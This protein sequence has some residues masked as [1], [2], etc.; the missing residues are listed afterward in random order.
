MTFLRFSR[1]TLL[2]LAVA[3]V[4][5]AAAVAAVLLSRSPP[6]SAGSG[7]IAFTNFRTGNG[8]IY[9][10]HHDGTGERRLTD[11]RAPDMFP[12]W[13]PD[14]KRI[15]FTRIQGGMSCSTDAQ[16]M[17]AVIQM[18]RIP[19]VDL[20]LGCMPKRLSALE[21]YVMNADGSGQHKLATGLGAVWSPEGRRIAYLRLLP[22]GNSDIYVV[23]LDGRSQRVTQTPATEDLPSWSPDGRRLAFDSERFSTYHGIDHRLYLVNDD[24]SG[25]RAL[26]YD[27]PGSTE[28]AWSPDGTKIA[29]SDSDGTISTLRPDR[30]R[31][32]EVPQ[33][34]REK[35]RPLS[36]ESDGYPVWS[37]DGSR[38]AF[39]VLDSDQGSRHLAL[40]RAD[41]TGLHHFA[42]AVPAL[43]QPSWSPDGRAIALTT[44]VAGRGRITIISADG[45]GR[46]V[47]AVRGDSAMPSWQP[48][49][50]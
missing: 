27:Q 6:A 47:L 43:L 36:S 12:V 33:A 46:R 11:D 5:A 23:G 28:P 37:R 25:L 35:K 17:L 49:G 14:G 10:V 34:L 8:D 42:F 9:T 7:L 31:A 13:S 1:S 22:K 39:V 3:L 29:F 48:S 38:L 18:E 26:T 40:V 16:D 20:V 21:L 45:S 2:V 41:G 32:G 24:A 44:S 19:F 50:A 4:V 30:S 15:A